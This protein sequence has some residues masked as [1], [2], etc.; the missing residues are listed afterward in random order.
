MYGEN[1]P[2]EEPEKLNK[3][4]SEE[5]DETR[6]TKLEGRNVVTKIKNFGHGSKRKVESWIYHPLSLRFI[7][8]KICI[9]RRNSS[10]AQCQEIQSQICLVVSPISFS[11]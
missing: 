6:K 8:F 7:Y 3:E 9:L 5:R 4:Q 1:C 10:T 2:E 11:A